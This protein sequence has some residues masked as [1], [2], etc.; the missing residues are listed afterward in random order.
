MK[1]QRSVAR[2]KSGGAEMLVLGVLFGS[3]ILLRAAG[4]L[5][6]EALASWQASCRWALGAMFLF[7]SLAHFGSTRHDLARMVP[8]QLPRPLLL[9]YL[10]GIFELLGAAGLIIPQTRV[11]ASAA[12][13]ILLVALFPANL[14]AARQGLTIAGRP[15]TPLGLRAPM[16]ALFLGLLWWAG[17]A[18]ASPRG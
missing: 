4:W 7:T 8:P 15:A 9:V 12:L 2:E 16:Q 13:M 6:V 1:K 5:G 11:A 10:T 14:R 17:V 3:W 18:A